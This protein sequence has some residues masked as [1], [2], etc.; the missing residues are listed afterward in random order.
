LLAYQDQRFRELLSNLWTHSPFYRDFYADHGIQE[1]HLAD[2]SV[3]DLPI[4]DK[5]T[6]M[7]N[8]DRIST[9]TILRRCEIEAWIH[10]DT[11]RGLYQDRYVVVHTSGSSGSLGIFVYDKSAWTRIRG[12]A[13]ARG[14]GIPRFNPLNRFRVAYYAATHG[15]FAG[16]TS[17]RL[18][19]RALYYIQ[20]CSVLDPLTHTIDRLNH[21]QPELL[22]GY[23]SAVLD[24]ANSAIA[25]ALRIRPGTIM[26]SGE[27]LTPEASKTIEQAWGVRPS[28]LY[29]TSESI[30]LGLQGP[31]C[32][33][34]SLVEDE[35]IFE[36]LNDRNEA[37]SA[38][39]VGRV[40][41]TSL[42]NRTIPLVRYELR[43]YVTRGFREDHE[44]FDHVLRV[45]GRVVDALPVT[46]RDGSCGSIHPV[47]LSEFFVPGVRMF[48]FVS[49]SPSHVNIRY[50]ANEEND[51]AVRQA[52]GRILA[53]KVAHPAV[54]V[55]VQRV[56]H[57]PGDARTGKH[58]L[59]I[60]KPEN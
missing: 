34:M 52:F 24:L 37:V 2:V 31:N 53:L 51:E 40:V 21:F 41:L 47:V 32:R 39:E 20:L 38:G 33:S 46:L 15:R 12:I 10:S 42:Y 25:G 1:R 27:V 18:L 4:V 43:D 44:P 11:S 59:V 22:V 26:T 56:K 7:E 17:V 45:E 48:Q 13:L 29:G 36:I 35:H 28:N 57:L 58:R 30:F 60:L 8:F 6:L 9:N 49:Q 3:R 5:E 54:K 14:M 23:P 50:V 19:P 16:V 55:F